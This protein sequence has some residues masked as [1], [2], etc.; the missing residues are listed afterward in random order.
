MLGVEKVESD[1]YYSASSWLIGSEKMTEWC[2]L[3]VLALTWQFAR[4][5]SA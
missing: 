3:I 4:D 5:V 1:A 2:I